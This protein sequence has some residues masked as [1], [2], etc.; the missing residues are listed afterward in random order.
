MCCRAVK[1]HNYS[2]L[3]DIEGAL[4]V[5]CPCT[6]AQAHTPYLWSGHQQWLAMTLPACRFP[7]RDYSYE[8]LIEPNAS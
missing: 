8:L 6:G 5:F 3:G 4:F 2:S 1:A 7:I